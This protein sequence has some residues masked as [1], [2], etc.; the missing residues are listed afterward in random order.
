[1]KRRSFFRLAAATPLIPAAAQSRRAPSAA[2]DAAAPPPAAIEATTAD[3]AAEPKPG[4]FT[5]AQFASMRRLCEIIMPAANSAP[6]ALQAGTPPFL[7]FLIGASPA[8]VQQL[9][10]E[11][12]DTLERRARE[13]F[14]NSFADLGAT[15]ADTLL[16]SLRERWTYDPPADPLA[17]FLRQAKQDIRMATLNSREYVSQAARRRRAASGVGQYWYPLD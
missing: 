12:L 6:G 2:A 1:M 13:R 16:A 5:P 3:A 8:G 14:G 17:R 4:F 11:G 9:Y 7:D 10:R 15:D